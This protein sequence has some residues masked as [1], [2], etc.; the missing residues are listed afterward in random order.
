MVP[1]PTA[2]MGFD[3]RFTE[4][5]GL[6]ITNIIHHVIEA[7]ADRS[8]YTLEESRHA[9]K[10]QKVPMVATAVVADVD[11][12]AGF[13]AAARSLRLEQ[14]YGK[15]PSPKPTDN[16]LMDHDT[17]EVEGAVNNADAFDDKVE[18]PAESTA[19]AKNTTF[20]ES[21]TPAL[22]ALVAEN[23]FLESST[24]NSVV[25]TDAKFG[26]HTFETDQIQPEQEN[27]ENLSI[28]KTWGTPAVRGKP[29]AQVRRVIIK[30]LPASWGTPDKILSLIHGGMID[31][32]SIAPSGHAHVL[33]CDPAAC[34]A[35]YDKYPNGIDVDKVRKFTVFVD[36]SDEVDVISSQLSFNLSVGATRIVRA[37]GI[38]MET[39]MNELVKLATSNRRKVEKI[40]DSYVPGYPRAVSFRFCS[41]DDA[42]RFRA[43]L[44]RKE[45]WEHC[46]VQ[47]ATDPCEVATGYHAD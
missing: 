40:I 21:P 27:R 12:T 41:I 38:D 45:D 3:K 15:P 34:K 19:P 43:A 6:N 44:V 20:V 42:V 25:A 7:V 4:L 39:T 46:N 29:G 47:Y 8:S 18:L 17:I 9:P 22:T 35:F 26:A 31:S 2:G 30:G 36:M 37:V 32:V 11:D 24:A 13:M 28:F 23:C 10:K 1:T 33:F 16:A 5:T 14:S